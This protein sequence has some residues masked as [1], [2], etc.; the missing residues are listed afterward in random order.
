MKLSRITSYNVC[1]TKLLRISSLVTSLAAGVPGAVAGVA[2]GGAGFIPMIAGY[3]MSAGGL[4]G[5]AEYDRFVD[6]A[7]SEFSKA[8]PSYNFV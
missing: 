2:T 4:F 3:A 6:D 5:L 8:N 7:Y 1:Y